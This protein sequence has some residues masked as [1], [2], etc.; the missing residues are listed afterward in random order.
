M[1][2]EP[3]LEQEPM[4]IQEETEMAFT[5]PVSNKRIATLHPK[6]REEAQKLFDKINNEVLTGRAKMRVTRAYATAAE[7]NALYAQ[8]RTKPGKIVTNARAGYSMHNYGLALDF[9]LIIDGRSASWD[10][11]GDYDKDG[12]KDWT[13]IVEVFKKAGWEWSGEWKTFKE[14]CHVQKAFGHNVKSLLT[15]PKDAAGYPKI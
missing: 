3:E 7:Q 2:P 9:C 11:L 10:M 14:Y 5:D 4:M 13:E 6:L 1:E 12:K 8:G 15:T